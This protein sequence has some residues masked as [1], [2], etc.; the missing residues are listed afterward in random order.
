MPQENPYSGREA[1]MFDF[2]CDAQKRGEH[3]F[4]IKIPGNIGPVERGDRFEDPLADKLSGLGVG[5]VCGG[6]SQLGEGKTIEYCGIDV[7]LTK[8]EEGLAVILAALRALDAPAGTVVEE[9]LPTRIDHPV[10][11]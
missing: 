4:Y 11:A 6:G 5:N 3:F 2:A 10:Y 8:R 9:Y 1:V 7:I